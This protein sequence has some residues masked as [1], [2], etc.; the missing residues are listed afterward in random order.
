[1][2]ILLNVLSKSLR[3]SA[4]ICVCF[5]RSW[6]V[7]FRW[8]M[9]NELQLVSI[10]LVFSKRCNLKSETHTQSEELNNSRFWGCVNGLHFFLG[11]DHGLNIFLVYD[12]SDALN[13]HLGRGVVLKALNARR[14]VQFASGFGHFAFG[15][16]VSVMN[17]YNY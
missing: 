15:G 8:L 17:K 16:W 2:A 4:N 12:A 10:S 13:E 9:D 5:F 14:F 1:V 7:V 6:L 11:N 3:N